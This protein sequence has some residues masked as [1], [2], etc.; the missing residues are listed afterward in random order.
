M[1]EDL[2]E[3]EK[4]IETLL[5]VEDIKEYEKNNEQKYKDYIHILEEY[6]KALA[7]KTETYN[8]KEL[9]WLDKLLDKFGTEMTILHKLSQDDLEAVVGEKVAKEIILAREGKMKLQAGGGGTYGRVA[10]E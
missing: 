2:K 1:N 6:S 3:I 8:E 9:E 4:T 10:K 7:D 5:E